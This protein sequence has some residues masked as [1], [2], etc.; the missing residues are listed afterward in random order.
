MTVT[1]S[2]VPTLKIEGSLSINGKKYTGKHIENWVRSGKPLLSIDYYYFA[3]GVTLTQ[4]VDGANTVR[5]YVSAKDLTKL[6]RRL[7]A[8]VKA[9]P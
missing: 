9:W 1:K 2:G 6:L 4:I 7:R 3:H 5:D 8:Y